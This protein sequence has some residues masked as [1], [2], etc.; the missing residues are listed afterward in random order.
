MLLFESKTIPDSLSFY[1]VIALEYSLS[2]SNLSG[3]P[4]LHPVSN[5]RREIKFQLIM[6]GW[7]LISVA[8]MKKNDILMKTVIP[9]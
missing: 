5:Q 8:C 6:F 7:T 9:G 2:F 1:C 3:E 4:S